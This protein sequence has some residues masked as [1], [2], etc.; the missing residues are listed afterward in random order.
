M[1]HY[2]AL[3]MITCILIFKMQS[4]TSVNLYYLEQYKQG[5]LKPKINADSNT[6]DNEKL[7]KYPNNLNIGNYFYFVRVPTLCYEINYPKSEKSWRI[8]YILQKVFQAF[9]HWFLIYLMVSEKIPPILIAINSGD[10]SLTIGLIHF[11]F[12][13]GII[14][15]NAFLFIFECCL[16]VYAETTQ[17]G[18]RLFY[19]D[20]WNSTNLDEFSRKW[21]KPIHEFLYRHIYLASFKKL[22]VSYINLYIYIYI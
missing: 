22:S 6:K 1:S 13:M 4:Y 5:K 12:P 3:F 2:M 15:L 14:C 10:M 21:N 20:W 7:L 9:I 8:G 17:F 18:D 16:N 19:Q 11:I